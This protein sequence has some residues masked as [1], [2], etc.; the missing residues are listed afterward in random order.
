MPTWTECV[1]TELNWN[2]Y[3]PPDGSPP[4]RPTWEDI[5]ARAREYFEAVARFC[6]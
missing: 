2:S 6:G 4:R 1:I 3:L 5:R